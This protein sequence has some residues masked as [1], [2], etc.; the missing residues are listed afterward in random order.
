MKKWMTLI[1][2]AVLLAGCTAEQPEPEPR[3]EEPVEII[4]MKGS[5]PGGQKYQAVIKVKDYGDIVFEMDEGIAPETVKNF[6]KLA[7]DGFYDGLTF[8]RLIEGF[9]A[10]GRSQCGWYR[11]SG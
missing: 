9:M 6:V 4:E 10:Q 3:E 11:R 2:S 8:H 5:E 1:L 7:Q